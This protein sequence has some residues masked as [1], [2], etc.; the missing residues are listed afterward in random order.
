[1]KRLI[2]FFALLL[3]CNTGIRGSVHGETLQLTTTVIQGNEPIYMIDDRN[4]S[5]VATGICPEII[6]AFVRIAPEFKFTYKTEFVPWPRVKDYLKH[7]AIQAQFGIARTAERER[8]YQYTDTPLYPVIFC[9]AARKD[10]SGIHHI[11]SFEDMKRSGGTVLGVLGANAVEVFRE[12]TKNLI[13][14]SR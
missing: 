14:L 4:G 6:R 13:S 2:V 3:I 11:N 5:P 1:M 10:D 8:W 9:F 12:R 7:N